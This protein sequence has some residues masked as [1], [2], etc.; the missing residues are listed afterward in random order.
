M[1]CLSVLFA[2]T[3]PAEGWLSLTEACSALAQVAEQRVLANDIEEVID[4][5]LQKGFI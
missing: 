3:P 5:L 4:T 1:R 2:D